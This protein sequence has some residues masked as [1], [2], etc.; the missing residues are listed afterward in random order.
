VVRGPHRSISR[1]K[2]SSG[3]YEFRDDGGQVLGTGTIRR[4]TTTTRTSI[5][6]FE[7]T[8]GKM[9]KVE[10]NEVIVGPGAGLYL[11][12]G[13]RM[14]ISASVGSTPLRS[15]LRT[16]FL[17]LGND[18]VPLIDLR[19]LPPVAPWRGH[20]PNGVATLGDGLEPTVDLVPL[21]SYAFLE[22]SRRMM[23]RGGGG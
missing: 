19:W 11:P 2:T 9:V 20:F 18:G 1:N 23:T 13:R 8:P 5:G 17:L 16:K 3:E 21:I 6:V 7:H 12:D 10:T 22:Y 4:T 15:A 14:T